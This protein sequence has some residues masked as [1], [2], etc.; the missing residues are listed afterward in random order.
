ETETDI[1]NTLKFTE[2]VQNKVDE[3]LEIASITYHDNEEFKRLVEYMNERIMKAFKPRKV[4]EMLDFENAI[5]SNEP[6]NQEE[7]P[8]DESIQ[9]TDELFRTQPE[10]KS[11][12]ELE[13][14]QETPETKLE[15]NLDGNVGG[16]GNEYELEDNLTKILLSQDDETN[17]LSKDD[18]MDELNRVVDIAVAY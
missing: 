13:A 1:K 15:A 9:S 12:T 2:S 7:E 16:D 6:L 17:E 8:N 5:E 18:E 14:V 11:P 3:M 10:C 4:A